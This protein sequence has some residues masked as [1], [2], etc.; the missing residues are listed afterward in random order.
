MKILKINSKV[1]GIKEVF[2]DNEDYEFIINF[3]SWSLQISDKKTDLFY[4]RGQKNKIRH[5][6]HRIIWE[7]YNKLDKKQKIDH[8]DN[9]GLNNQ[10]E[11]LR[12]ATTKQN[13]FNRRKNIKF[14]ST[15]KGVSKG[16]RNWWRAGIKLDNKTISIK[17]FESER[18]AAIAYDI[19]AKKYFG[20]FAKPNILDPSTEE[21]DKVQKLIDSFISRNKTSKYFGVCFDKKNNKWQSQF[22]F[23]N[24]CFYIGQFNTEK[25]AVLAYNNKAKELLGN[26]AKLN[27]INE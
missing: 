19:Y 12:I 10:K 5:M 17:N 22:W 18:D 3:C 23:H 6:M 25:E 15:Y 24:K 27:I 14:T 20:E 21:T 9:N 2:L 1:Y 26:N 13:G 11:N 8:K 7:R 4:C 16:Y